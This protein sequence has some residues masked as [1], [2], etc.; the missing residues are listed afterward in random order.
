MTL[1]CFT[2]P[3]PP[4]ACGRGRA[5]SRPDPKAPQG[6]ALTSPYTSDP[7]WLPTGLPAS[8]HRT[9]LYRR[10]GM[11]FPDVG[12]PPSFPSF[13]PHLLQ[14]VLLRYVLHTSHLSH[15]SLGH[16]AFYFILLENGLVYSFDLFPVWLPPLRMPAPQ[17]LDLVCPVLPT[18]RARTG[19]GIW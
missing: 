15:H 12:K 1:T 6:L 16:C 10:P 8:G 11:I 14:E 18:S 7:P 19:L 4:V 2:L 17:R 13:E 5:A 3:W 9:L